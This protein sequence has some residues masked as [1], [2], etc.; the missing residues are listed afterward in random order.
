[1]FLPLP[2]V[3]FEEY[4]LLDDRPAH[5]MDFYF[6]L[7]FSD[8]LER[9]PLTAALGAV[10]ARHPLLSALVAPTDR[11]GH[12]WIPAGNRPPSVRWRSAPSRNGLGHVSPI[13]LRQETGVRLHVTQSPSGTDL[14]AQFHHAC[15]DGLAAAAFL[16][17]LLADYAL[18]IGA[19]AGPPVTC[20]PSNRLV[21]PRRAPDLLYARQQAA[22]GRGSRSGRLGTWDI[23]AHAP[24]PMVPHRPRPASA[25]PPASYPAAMTRE[26]G[27]SE[28]ATF[29]ETAR[30]LGVTV[31]D[32]LVRDVF[33]AVGQ[34]KA[35]R[36][37]G[38]PR[39]RLRLLI[40]ISLRGRTAAPM[41][42]ANIV[43]LAFVDRRPKDF[44]DPERLLA[45]VHRQMD[46]IK[47]TNLREAF[48]ACLQTL[49]ETP[50]EIARMTAAD[51][52]WTTGVLSNFGAPF[53]NTALPLR[54][55]Y[56]VLDDNV[57]EGIDIAVPLRPHTC[58]ALAVFTYAGRLGLTLHY[59]PEPFR[60][61]WADELLETLTGCV[62]E[63]VSAE[64]ARRA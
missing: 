50:G 52:C 58:V 57:L 61:A 63:S 14:V 49:A 59:D 21:L 34:W 12:A 51:R 38:L 64:Y 32:L 30:E 47:H 55:G 7:R 2:L 48:L 29:C 27:L 33:L 15:C 62:H 53:Q 3:P 36:C 6:R 46:H 10:L 56:V 13:D 22:I 54:D 16:E 5:P 23:F 28:T 20:G 39:D 31:N 4:M 35:C 45:G 42:A 26:L 37:P 44:T 9:G 60:P 1:M 19:I 25:A 41:P 11:D 43:S 24:V 8:R 18:R 17:E 40:P